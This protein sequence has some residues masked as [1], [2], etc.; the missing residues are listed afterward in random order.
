MRVKKILIALAMVPVVAVIAA[1]SSGSGTGPDAAQSYNLRVNLTDKPM[2]SM[3]SVNVSI[4]MVRVHQSASADPGAA[5]WHDMP[6]TATMPIDLMKVRNG[7]VQELC[8]TS[9]D[10]GSYQQMRLVMTP[11]AGPGDASHNNVMT[12]DGVTHPVEMPTDVKIVHPFTIGAGKTDITLDF[13]ASDSMH[14]RGNGTYYMTP[15]IHPST[16]MQ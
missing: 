4:A 13:I 15:V 1:C 2:M 16:M 9:L 14:Q 5:G 11:N 12:M 10:P 8:R 6:V 7:V 3:Q